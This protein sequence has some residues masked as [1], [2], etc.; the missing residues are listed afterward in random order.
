MKRHVHQAWSPEIDKFSAARKV[1]VG[2]ILVGRL[3]GEV[4]LTAVEMGVGEDRTCLHCSAHGAV[5]DGKSRRLQRNHCRSCNR[6][7]GTVTDAP[8]SGLHRNEPWLTFDKWL[9]N[10]DTVAV[11]AKCYDTVLNIAF[12]PGPAPTPRN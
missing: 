4:S 3:A 9:A 6:T 7:F 1:G 11:A 5:A 8:L 2:E 10:G 12:L